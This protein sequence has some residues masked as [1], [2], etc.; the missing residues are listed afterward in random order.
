[1]SGSVFPPDED[2]LKSQVEEVL[3]RW[4]SESLGPSDLIPILQE[5]QAEVGY[6]P[7]KA[8]ER[9]SDQMKLPPSHVY[10]VAT[11]YHQFRMRPEGE[12]I[13]TICQG[14]ACHV[15]GA[16]DINRFLMRHLKIDPSDDT[17]P[18]RLFTVKQVR[19]IGACSLS[20][21]IK[22]DDEVHGKLDP[23]KLQRILARY[24]KEMVEDDR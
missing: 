12:H 5:I 1:M 10:G 9:V 16:E 22:I 15:T 18:D 17:S 24:R 2:E 3:K 14:T 19:C 8:L 6:L 21:V 13:V 20:P 23:R 11:F 4:G 7:R